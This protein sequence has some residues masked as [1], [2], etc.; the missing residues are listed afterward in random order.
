MTYSKKKSLT[1][2]FKLLPLRLLPLLLFN[3]FGRATSNVPEFNRLI[4][5]KEL[6]L[7]APGDP[8]IC[9]DHQRHQ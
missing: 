6:K 1:E 3:H 8:L 7:S 9:F 5:C 2:R 4:D